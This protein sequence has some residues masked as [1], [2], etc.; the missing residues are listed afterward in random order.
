M[1]S[2]SLVKYNCNLPD[3][4][5]VLSGRMVTIKL[6][7]ALLLLVSLSAVAC[8]DSSQ[9]S[10][11]DLPVGSADA[12]QLLEDARDSMNAL[13]SYRQELSLSPDGPP[14]TISVDFVQPDAYYERFAQGSSEGGV[15]ELIQADGLIYVRQ[16]ADY[17]RVCEDWESSE[18]S[19]EVPSLGGLTTV[20]PETFGLTALDMMTEPE[21]LESESVDGQGLLRV[22]GSLNL[23]RA[24]YENQRLAFQGDAGYGE[25]CETHI[26]MGATPATVCRERTFEEAYEEDYGEVDFDQAPSSR[27]EVL[28]NRGDR[29][30]HSIKV[31]VPLADDDPYFESTYSNFNGVTIEVPDDAVLAD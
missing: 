30:V 23:A 18:A 15:V 1:C 4:A 27:I 12:Q 8:G 7:A 25:S 3:A 2:E 22:R 20:A 28:L 10:E 24:I 11:A 5:C 17:P 29:Y 31:S 16:C 6:A 21:I 9:E 14:I 19:A 13:S 26:E